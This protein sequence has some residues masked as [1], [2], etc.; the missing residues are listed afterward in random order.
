[1]VGEVANRYAKA[2]YD[3]AKETGK[4]DEILA[5]LRELSKSFGS[6]EFESFFSQKNVTNTDK[7]LIVKKAIA[8]TKVSETVTSFI[9]ILAQKGRL[10]L[11]S[12][13]LF[14]YE[15]QS[16]SESNVVRGTV[17]SAV[18]LLP[19]QRQ[20]LEDIVAKVTHKKAILTYSVVPEIIGGLVA[21]VGSYTFD[22][23][24]DTHLKKL[25]EDLK[26]RAH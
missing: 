22:D 4:K 23:T 12:Q 7:V 15:A 1:M 5:E 26:R 14:S 24:I 16:D 25:N 8:S 3:L 9:S 13:I 17:E 20:Q 18:S 21:K 2:I 19:E 6:P 10:S 11:F